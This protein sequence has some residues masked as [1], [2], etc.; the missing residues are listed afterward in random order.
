MK[1]IYDIILEAPINLSF[2]TKHY[3]FMKFNEFE[4]RSLQALLN[5]LKVTKLN[6]NLKYNIIAEGPYRTIGLSLYS[7]T[8]EFRNTIDMIIVNILDITG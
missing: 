8:T 4:I 2:D 3:R 1:N 5:I 7:S 6:N